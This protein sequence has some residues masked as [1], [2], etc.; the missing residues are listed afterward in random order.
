MSDVSP[1]GRRRKASISELEPLLIPVGFALF[2][3]IQIASLWFHEPWADEIQA[4]LLARDSGLWELLSQRLKYEA[5]PGLWHTVLWFCTRVTS[6]VTVTQLASVI[7]ATVSAG[8]IFFASPFPWLLRLSLP[9]TY[10]LGYQYSIVARNYCITTLAI[11]VTAMLYG[12]RLERPGQYVLALLVMAHSSSHGMLIAAGIASCDLF[13]M[14]EWKHRMRLLKLAPVFIMGMLLSIAQFVPLPDD[15]YFSA[16]RG[17]GGIR[18]PNLSVWTCLDQGFFGM[19]L[20]SA[21]LLVASLV[22]FYRCGVLAVYLVPTTFLFVLF[23]AKHW[24]FWHA[25]TFFLVWLFCLYLCY[26]KKHAVTDTVWWKAVLSVFLAVSIWQAAQ[27]VRQDIHE[28]YFGLEAVAK[29][30]QHRQLDLE[31]VLLFGYYPQMLWAYFP[32]EPG[33]PRYWVW[34]DQYLNY[35]ADVLPEYILDS[36]AFAANSTENFLIP[37][38]RGYVLE[39]IYRGTR[40][41][42][43]QSVFSVG[44]FALLKRGQTDSV[45]IPVNR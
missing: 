13:P 33:R 28:P 44:S 36:A 31:T 43:G 21:V 30:F 23:W 10:F 14:K 15:Y 7:I 26:S 1:K 37:Q 17:G 39:R 2:V 24:A 22:V 35:T 3:T 19:P 45:S 18:Y 32:P 4:F 38:H 29:D 5:T 9:F 20:L 16:S 41:W 25:G 42:K 27:T 12:R 8:L 11:I 40:P 6:D 34:S